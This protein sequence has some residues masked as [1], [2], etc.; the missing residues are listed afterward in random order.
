MAEAEKRFDSGGLPFTSLSHSAFRNAASAAGM[1]CLQ[2]CQLRCARPFRVARRLLRRV[3]GASSTATSALSN[4]AH[5]GVS[6]SSSCG[7]SIIAVFGSPA[8]G[9]ARFNNGRAYLYWLLAWLA[10]GLIVA[11]IAQRR[12]EDLNLSLFEPRTEAAW[13]VGGAVTLVT[14]PLALYLSVQHLLHFVKPQLQVWTIDNGV[15]LGR[16]WVE[17]GGRLQYLGE[18]SLSL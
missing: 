16:G 3:G 10:W 15:E 5:S 8:H 12:L 6:G 11:L 2:G 7:S 14:L 13:V 17:V 9:S 18:C 1:A 4:P